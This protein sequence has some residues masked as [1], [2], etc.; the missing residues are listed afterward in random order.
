M[1]VVTHEMNFARN[2]SNKVIF[3]EEGKVVES[4][5]SREFFEHPKQERSREFLSRIDSQHEV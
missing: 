1:L 4:G 3:M 5:A 2:V